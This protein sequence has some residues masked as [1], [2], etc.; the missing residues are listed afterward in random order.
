[1]KADRG[2]FGPL[3]ESFVFSEVLKLMAASDLRLTPH[4]FR[5]RDMRGVDIVLE[6]DDGMI[7]GIEAK[8]SATVKVSDFGGSGL[9][10][11]LAEI[12]SLSASS[13]MTTRM[14]YHSATAWRRRHCRVCGP[15]TGRRDCTREW[16]VSR[17]AM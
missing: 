3:L 12:A 2:T 9:W 8:A 15:E 10:P 6:R 16:A 5:D 14:S 4:H 1:V 13:S 7:M 11:R 17:R